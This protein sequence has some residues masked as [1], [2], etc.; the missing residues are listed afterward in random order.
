[1]KW[2]IGFPI[3]FLE[4]A[5]QERWQTVLMEDTAE[6]SG[7][8]SMHRLLA[9][10]ST[11]SIG[12]FFFLSLF[13]FLLSCSSFTML[14]QFLLC[15]KVNQSHR[16]PLP[17][18]SFPFRSPQS[19]EFPV[20]YSQFLLAI[21]F[22]NSSVY[23]LIP[24]SQSIPFPF[25]LGIHMFVLYISVSIFALQISSS[26]PYSRFHIYALIYNICFSLSCL[27]HSV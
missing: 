24:T 4:T 1:M 3:E 16:S 10:P 20:L 19:I 14:Y 17:C 21:C 13:F 23:M 27:L 18:I 7:P 25:P 22:I 2:T 8:W 6:P 11:T 26:I 15:S 5:G 9:K 12:T